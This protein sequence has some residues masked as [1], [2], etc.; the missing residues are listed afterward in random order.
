MK[1]DPYRLARMMVAVKAVGVDDARVL[2]AM[3]AVPREIFVSPALKNE[4]YMDKTLPIGFE[5][6]ISAPS[7]VGAMTQALSLTGTEKVLEVGT[8]C[9]Y[10]CAVLAK[11]AK[12]VF[13]VER[14]AGLAKG[15][16]ERL[17]G[18]GLHNVVTKVGDGRLGWPEQ[19]PFDGIIVTAAGLD[20]PA[21]L[22]E[23]LVVGGRMVIPVGAQGQRQKLL[24]IVRTEAGFDE[25]VLGLVDFV[26]LLGA[27]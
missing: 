21:S 7:V 11:C 23:Q 15:A 9:G 25:E 13:S 20:V 10:Q 17:R 2:A 1:P 3:E 19:A 24:R 12:R 14:I 22:R 27:S 6:T 18:M 8:G 4:A 5:Q 26:P 16:E